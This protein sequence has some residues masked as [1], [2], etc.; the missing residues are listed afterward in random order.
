MKKRTYYIVD[1]KGRPLS[2]FESH[3]LITPQQLKFRGKDCMTFPTKHGANQYLLHI[4]IN[5]RQKKQAV[6]LVVSETCNW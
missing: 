2:Q 5:C 6:K 3:N 1:K 4:N